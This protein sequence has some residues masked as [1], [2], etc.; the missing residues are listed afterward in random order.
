MSEQLVTAMFIFTESKRRT[1]QGES[2]TTFILICIEDPFETSHDLGRVIDKIYI[3]I[4]I[5]IYI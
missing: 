4:Y 2:G 3:Y 5:Y 1:G